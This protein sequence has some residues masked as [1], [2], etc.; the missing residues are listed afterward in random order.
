MA[1][2]SRKDDDAEVFIY[3]RRTTAAPEVKLSIA[4]IASFSEFKEK[5]K[6]VRLRLIVSLH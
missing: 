1:A 4:G 2:P 3:D 6:G 5:V